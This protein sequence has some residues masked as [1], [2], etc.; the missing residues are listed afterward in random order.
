MPECE[1]FRGYIKPPADGQAGCAPN[2]TIAWHG[3]RL[4]G[5]APPQCHG[6][7]RPPPLPR[8]FRAWYDGKLRGHPSSQLGPQ[9]GRVRRAA[10]TRGSAQWVGV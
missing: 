4:R 1:N 10:R 5:L 8:S 6:P 2:E 7:R 3:A 9:S